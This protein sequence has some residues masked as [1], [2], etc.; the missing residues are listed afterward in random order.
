MF[1]GKKKKYT[2]F[3]TCFQN[4]GLQSRKGFV[5]IGCTNNFRTVDNTSIVSSD[6]SSLDV[7]NVKPQEMVLYCT[8]KG[9][10]SFKS[11]LLQTLSI[12]FRAIDQASHYDRYIGARMNYIGISGKLSRKCQGITE[13]LLKNGVKCCSNQG[14]TMKMIT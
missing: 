6:V 10:S 5:L 12:M 1:R 14:L 2:F 9:T 7:W 4:C 11:F 8:R 3:L 13:I